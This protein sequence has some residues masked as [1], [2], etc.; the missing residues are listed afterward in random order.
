MKWICLAI[1]ALGTAADAECRQALALGLDISG[2]VDAREYRLQ[3]DGLAAALMSDEVQSA[4]FAIRSSHV[5]VAVYEWS[6]QQ[7]TRI[8]VPWTEV[9]APDALAGIATRLSQARRPAADTTTALGA[10]MTTGATLLAERDCWRRVLDLSGDGISNTG[11]RPRDIRLSDSEL[12]INGLVVAAEGA[13]QADRSPVAA[14]ELR[15]YFEAEVIRGPHSFV[16]TA[17]GFENY[18]NA[19][20]RKLLRELQ[21]LVIGDAGRTDQ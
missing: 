3:L 18:S 1:L 19:I 5:D 2:S 9:T 21:V 14:H 16:E 6:G 20:K 11:P 8:T 17:I 10:A 13:S 15:R 12:T 4:F 7:S